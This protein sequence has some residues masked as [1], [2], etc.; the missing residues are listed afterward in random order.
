MTAIRFTFS[1]IMA[2]LF[3]TCANADTP[4]ST[5]DV[6]ACAPIENDTDRLACFDAAVGRLQAAEESGELQTLSRKEIETVQKDAF[7]FSLPSLPKL[8]FG[9]PKPK[10]ET[11]EPTET[12]VVKETPPKETK[13]AKTDED[14]RLSSITAAV[15]DVK[16]SKISG[17][18]VTLDN[19]QVWRQSEAK[20]IYYSR[21]K[22]VKEATIKRGRF[23]GFRMKLDDGVAF[24]VKRIK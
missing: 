5:D 13:T 10:K 11:T 6:Y 7:G 4:T 21:K 20:K 1:A 15:T 14:G 23:G 24:Q 3:M 17:L 2:G 16:K 9:K 8:S 22:G 12:A 18:T 19:G